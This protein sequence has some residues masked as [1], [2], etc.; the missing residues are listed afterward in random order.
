[1]RVRDTFVRERRRRRH[2]KKPKNLFFTIETLKNKILFV[3][4]FRSFR[5]EKRHL[6]VLILP[7]KRHTQ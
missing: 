4:F 5:H 7:S 2:P 1:M 6:K 3:F